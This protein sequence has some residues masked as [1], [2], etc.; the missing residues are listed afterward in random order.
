MT[1]IP[2][3]IF[4]IDAK[5]EHLAIKEAR[6]L[7]IPV[8]GVIDTN[9][10]PDSVDYPIPANDDSVK[11]ADIITTIM[12]DAVIEASAVARARKAEFGFD[13]DQKERNNERD[14]DRQRR[15]RDRGDRG[16]RGEGRGDRR[17]RPSSRPVAGANREGSDGNRGGAPRPRREGGRPPNRDNQ[18]PPTDTPKTD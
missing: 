8:I 2:G 9:T 18:A 7:G 17:D 3:A 13:S 6:V 11:T 4:V 15:F 10:D 5:K 12:A 16:G 1:R 14:G